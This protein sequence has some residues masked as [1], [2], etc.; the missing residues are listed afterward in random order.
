MCLDKLLSWEVDLERKET[1]EL[2]LGREGGHSTHRVVH[3]KDKTGRELVN[4]LVVLVKQ[5]PNVTLLEHHQAMDLIIGNRFTGRERY[6]ACDVLDCN[7]DR[8]FRIQS[9]LCVLASGGLGHLYA[10]NTNPSAATG[11]GI[12][13]AIRAGARQTRCR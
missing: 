9:K 2:S 6:A 5:L 12:A 13:M 4:R 3:H 1:G 8:V 11:D 7:E 10:R